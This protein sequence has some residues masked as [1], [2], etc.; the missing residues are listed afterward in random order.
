MDNDKSRIEKSYEDIIE[1]TNQKATKP[2]HYETDAK[3][4]Q[5]KIVF[6][7]QKNFLGTEPKFIKAI[8]KLVY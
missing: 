2:W 4:F 5:N 6:F 1:A 7:V 3:F 8:A